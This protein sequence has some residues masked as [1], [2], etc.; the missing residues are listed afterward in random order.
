MMGKLC[1]SVIY[2]K[3][4]AVPEECPFQRFEGY[5]LKKKMLFN[6][7]VNYIKSLTF[8]PLSQHITVFDEKAELTKE[9]ERLVFLTNKIQIVTKEKG[10][11]QST[12]K[13]LMEKYGVSLIVSNS[14]VSAVKDSTFIISD[15]SDMIPI[16]YKGTLFTNE[17]KHLSFGR[18][19]I[20]EGIT[21]PIKYGELIPEGFDEME[22]ALALYEKCGVKQLEKLSFDTLLLT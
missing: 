15:K 5:E 16:Y 19:L 3:D 21:L 11:Y 18:V 12:A 8:D 2:K 13:F 1:D 20:G 22:F 10:R 6:S 14:F 4:S 9:I 17:K 7:A